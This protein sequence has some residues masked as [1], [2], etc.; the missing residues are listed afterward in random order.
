MRRHDPQQDVEAFHR[1]C[2]LPIGDFREPALRDVDLRIELIE[3]ELAELKKAIATDDLA[4]ATD[5]L[6]D[7]MYVTIGAAV[8]WGVHLHGP[9]TEVQRTNMAKAP[10]GVVRRRED[11]KI[12]KP[13]GWKPPDME[14]VLKSQ[15]MIFGA[16]EESCVADMLARW[17]RKTR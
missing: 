3:E 8:T 14:G 11:G 17:E 7:I 6:I 12:L 16:F 4:A 9:W 15:K 5:A 2:G 10:D 13:E 1:L